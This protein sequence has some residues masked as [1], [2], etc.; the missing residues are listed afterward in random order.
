[1][2][3]LDK[4]NFNNDPQTG[5][6]WFFRFY[7]RHNYS[8]QN[9][10]NI[11]N[12]EPFGGVAFKLSNTGAG[13]NYNDTIVIMKIKYVFRNISQNTQSGALQ[14]SDKNKFRGRYKSSGDEEPYWGIQCA[15]GSVVVTAG[16]RV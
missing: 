6:G 16:G 8:S 5:G 4:L 1:V 13:E 10:D 15:R 7:T 2:F 12:Q 9:G 3:N 14:D 11:Y